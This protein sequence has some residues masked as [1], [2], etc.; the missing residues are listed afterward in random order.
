[1]CSIVVLLF[2]YNSPS[3]AHL[4]A[5]YYMCTC[6]V[7]YVYIMYNNYSLETLSS[8][9]KANAQYNKTTPETTPFLYTSCIHIQV[10]YIVYV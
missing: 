6:C 7:S 5:V 8:K 2:A 1:M 3:P 10:Q 9:Q 4:Y